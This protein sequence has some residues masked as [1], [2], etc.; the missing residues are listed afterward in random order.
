VVGPSGA[1]DQAIVI[2]NGTTG[3]L[4]ADSTVVVGSLAPKAS[5]ALTG[6]PT[7][8]TAAAGTDTT[9]IATTAF[10][11]DEVAAVPSSI[12]SYEFS[13]ST[14]TPPGANQLRFDAG[15]PYTAV[16]KVWA[17]IV[18]AGG[19]DVFNALRL[20]AV[21]DR[22][23]VQDKN[24][25]TQYVSFT[26]S[27]APID[28]TTYFEIP[29][30][31][32]EHGSALSGGQPV[33]FQSVG[34]GSGATS[35][36]VTHTVGAL[37]DHAV[38]VGNGADDIQVL[39]SLG[40]SVLV[41][42]GNASGDPTWSAVSLTADVTGVLP[43]ANGGAAQAVGTSDTPQFARVGL[44]TAADSSA[45]LKANGQIYSATK[46]DGNTSTA[47]TFNWNDSNNHEATMTGA[48]AV[49]LSNP[50]DGAT[51]GILLKGGAGGFTP[52]WPGTVVWGNGVSPTYPIAS[53]HS[54]LV[55]MQYFASI[56]KYLAGWADF[57]A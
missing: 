7:A 44:G 40:T 54:H 23:N 24:D 31:H 12:F 8:P 27:G 48:A 6:T 17:R 41:L 50:K 53:G 56:S 29:V 26:V 45:V 25:H 5:P 2:F 14:S 4:L 32:L 49:T 57:V 28:N 21:G 43:A 46:D 37:T 20:L 9:Q 1:V 30:T 47:V 35:G 18:T 42:H 22:I 38:V 34:Q 33:L 55:R 39:S 52:T 3:K 13:A 10:V 16:T 36:T 19:V 15:S 51:Y 11:Q